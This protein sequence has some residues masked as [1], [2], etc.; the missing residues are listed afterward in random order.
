MAHQPAH[1]PGMRIYIYAR[2]SAVCACATHSRA[3]ALVSACC[4]RAG[5]NRDYTS[6]VSAVVTTNRIDK[7]SQIND[8]F[9]NKQVIPFMQAL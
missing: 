3:R 4:G 9:T 2:T 8:P 7:T 1:G 6:S 5:H